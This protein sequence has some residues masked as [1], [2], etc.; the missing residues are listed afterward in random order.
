[1]R[2]HAAVHLVV[3][4]VPLFLL[5]GGCRRAADSSPA[6]SEPARA[7]A[8]AVI[9]LDTVAHHVGRDAEMADLLKQ[10]EAALNEQLQAAQLAYQEQ[11]SEQRASLGDDPTNEQLHQLAQMQR[12]ANLNLNQAR[13]QAENDLQRHRSQLVSRFR[14]EVKPVARVVAAERGLSIIVTKNDTVVFTYDTTADIT[15][16]VIEAMARVPGI[17]MEAVAEG[18]AG[19]VRR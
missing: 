3:C 5:A 16:E 4:S 12:Q 17:G 8:V 2:L 7:G 13:V 18:T 10:R 6:V 19:A 11:I 9:D 14:D 15:A 1:M